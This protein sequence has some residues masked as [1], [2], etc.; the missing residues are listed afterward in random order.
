MVNYF[1]RCAFFEASTVVTGDYLIDN[2]IGNFA[3]ASHK[4][5]FEKSV[6]ITGH[7]EQSNGS[8]I[9]LAYRAVMNLKEAAS[10]TFE[11]L[12]AVI[13]MCQTS[14]TQLP[15]NSVV[16]QGLAGIDQNVYCLDL[17]QGCAG[18]NYSYEL[19]L[20]RVAKTGRACLVV[21]SDCYQSRISNDANTKL[22]FSDVAFAYL[23][24][25]QQLGSIDIVEQYFWNDGVGIADMYCT[26]DKWLA[27]RFGLIPNSEIHM[28]GPAIYNFAIGS[29]TEKI[30][31]I[32][33][34]NNISGSN[35]KRVYLHQANRQLLETLSSACG[36][37]SEAVPINVERYANTVSASIPLL[38]AEDNYKFKQGDLALVVGFGVG[39][40]ISITLY[41]M[42]G[43]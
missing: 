8:V 24:G 27:S 16:L 2:N 15:S 39:L 20:H 6:G 37:D 4:R 17:N 35:I 10:A 40:S 1:R 19:A 32:L 18:F 13:F 30:K 28:N 14:Q 3:S 42:K 26:K 7:F 38:I 11:Q 34:R 36:F 12:G 22:L 5:R 29:V 25:P 9:D 31:Y 33:E 23:L 41:K 21:H 43:T